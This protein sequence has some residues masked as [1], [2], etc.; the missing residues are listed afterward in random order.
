MK[1]MNMKHFYISVIFVLCMIIFTSPLSAYASNIRIEVNDELLDPPADKRPIRIDN[2][3]FIPLRLVADAIGLSVD[4]NGQTQ[5]ASIETPDF[6]AYIQIGNREMLVNDHFVMLDAP[7]QILND[8]TIMTLD[9]IAEATGMDVLWNSNIIT[10]HIFEPFPPIENWPE[11]LPKHVPGSITLRPVEQILGRHWSDPP[12]RFR[13][14]FYNVPFDI[15]RLIDP[16]ELESWWP[17]SEIYREE[18]INELMRFVQHF[19][20]SREDFDAVI[21]RTRERGLQ[22]GV[23]F[24][25]EW[26]ELPNADIIFTFDNDL[27]RYF[28]RRQ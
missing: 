12:M 28:Y 7:A 11:H 10:I 19:N 13:Y 14:A 15:I 1:Q 24:T 9:D 3:V 22:V 23:D 8:R 25:D 20:I 16:S 4:W 21:E 6:V 2:H 26:H 27:I 18:N 17:M 5:T